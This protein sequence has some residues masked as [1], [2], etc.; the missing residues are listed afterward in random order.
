MEKL[1][2]NWD[3]DTL[4]YLKR[5]NKEV[6]NE[7]FV[8]FRGKYK[9]KLWIVEYK[10][11]YGNE[12]WFRVPNSLAWNS[13]NRECDDSTLKFIKNEIIKVVPNMCND[14]Y[15]TQNFIAFSKLAF[16]NRNDIEYNY[17]Y[18]VQILGC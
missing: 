6:N 18:M 16:D 11:R 5:T 8:K 4:N 12:T 13:V 14:V 10:P 1:K 7:K 15:F 9:P 3:E 2:I 17:N